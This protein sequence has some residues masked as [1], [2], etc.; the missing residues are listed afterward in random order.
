[1]HILYSSWN[2]DIINVGLFSDLF[3]YFFNLNVRKHKKNYNV[4]EYLPYQLMNY[5]FNVAMYITNKL[6]YFVKGQVWKG[7]CVRRL[8]AV[9]RRSL[10]FSHLGSQG[11]LP[12]LKQVAGSKKESKRSIGSRLCYFMGWLV[13]GD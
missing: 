2:F 8:P 1:M 10:L 5:T 6:E 3:S 7:G 12:L 11:R 4:P 9:L 13:Y